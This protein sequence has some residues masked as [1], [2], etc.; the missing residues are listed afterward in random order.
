MLLICAIIAPLVVN[1]EHKEQIA[2]IIGVPAKGKRKEK[3][4]G[5]AAAATLLV[6]FAGLFG[7]V[8]KMVVLW[9]ITVVAHAALCQPHATAMGDDEFQSELKAIQAWCAEI[10]APKATKLPAKSVPSSNPA[11]PLV[12]PPTVTM[13]AA[14]TSVKGKAHEYWAQNR[15]V[16]NATPVA[17]ATEY[18]WG[19]RGVSTW[20]RTTKSSTLQAKCKAGTYTFT[21]RAK[22]GALRSKVATM[23][24]SI[25]VHKARVSAP[26]PAWAVAAEAAPELTADEVAKLIAAAGSGSSTS[27]RTIFRAATT[28]TAAKAPS[29]KFRSVFDILKAKLD[30]AQLLSLHD[31]RLMEVECCG[32]GSASSAAFAKL[33]KCS[34]KVRLMYHGTEDSSIAA[35]VKAGFDDSKIAGATDEG[36]IGL[37]HYQTP[38]PEYAAAY[39]KGKTGV[40]TFKYD[41]PVDVGTTVKLIV[42]L[43]ATTAEQRKTTMSY[44]MSLDKGYDATTSWVTRSGAPTAADASGAS[45]AYVQEVVVR[46]GSSILPRFVVKLRRVA[47]TLVWVDP[48]ITGDANDSLA[49]KLQLDV[50]NTRIVTTSDRA[51]ALATIAGCRL[52]PATKGKE[53]TEVR[54][55]TAGRGG[56]ELLDKLKGGGGASAKFP[57]EV[58]ALVYCSAVDW[59]RTWAG[60]LA[61]T[62]VTGST[63]EMKNFCSW[64]SGDAAEP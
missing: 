12:P 61:A 44:G 57:D 31:F 21:C 15:V 4:V 3:I 27:R 14:P 29:S 53:N 32:Q 39:L 19:I 28:G 13:L 43:V 35:I 59:H 20:S 24:T 30:E 63:K 36:F 62:K 22:N 18:E 33:A 10:T 5:I 40:T 55:V 38:N 25:V 9:M 48:N 58:P 60:K 49:R 56:F 8:C 34:T 7:L 51:K 64:W 42:S 16:V 50:T 11:A 45:G 6:I 46:H 52:Q 37:G 23:T 54:V 41:D 1:N 47:K 2:L 26:T 17:N